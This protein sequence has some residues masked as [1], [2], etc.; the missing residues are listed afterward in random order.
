MNE[1]DQA[2]FRAKMKQT[3]TVYALAQHRT[4]GI[5]EIVHEKTVH[6]I[7]PSEIEACELCKAMP[8]DSDLAE[9]LRHY[10]YSVN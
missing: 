10:K 6:G 7:T 3:G 1:K 2:A 4:T 9:E 8:E 5:I